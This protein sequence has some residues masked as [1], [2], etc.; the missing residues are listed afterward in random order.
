MPHFVPQVGKTFSFASFVPKGAGRPEN[1]PAE[2]G[3]VAN[4]VRAVVRAIRSTV[5]RGTV[6][7]VVHPGRA[8]RTWRSISGKPSARANRGRGTHASAL[9][10]MHP[11][12][13]FGRE[14]VVTVLFQ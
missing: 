6:L 8:G 2:V 12:P 5:R 7:V 1:A 11:I 10:A 4:V 14:S 9:P 3:V 13:D